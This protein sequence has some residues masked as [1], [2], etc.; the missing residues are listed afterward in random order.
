MMTWTLAPN[1]KIRSAE[2]RAVWPDI[3]I[4]S[5]GDQ[6]HQAECSDH[7]PDARGIVHA[8]DIMTQTDTSYDSAAATNLAWLHH[9]TTD[10]QYFIHDRMIYSR[11][12][13]FVGINYTGSDPHTNHIH[14]SGK[15]GTTGANAAT[16]NGYSIAAENYTPGGIMVDLSPASVAAVANAVWDKTFT[17]SNLTPPAPVAASTFIQSIN[18]NAAKA[19]AAAEL[20]ATNPA[21]LAAALAPLLSGSVTEDELAAAL[22]TALKELAATDVP[23]APGA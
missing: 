19:R 16:C 11:S 17:N 10:L 18:T 12:H 2:V 13:G 9:D 6:A 8:I 5:V 3:V 21:P 14:V 1:L 15:H 20:I 22:V 23:A 7:N 4:Y